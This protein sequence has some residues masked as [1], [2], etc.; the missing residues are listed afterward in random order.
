MLIELY[1]GT[2]TRYYSEQ[3]E[4]SLT[5][6]GASSPF[7]GPSN[8][9][10]VVDPVELQGIVSDWREKASEKL[11]EHLPEPLSWQEGMLPP[12]EAASLTFTGYG[13]AILF[14]A[15][16]VTE[17]QPRPT[18][19]QKTWDKD[20][21]VE[22]LMKAT[23]NNAI[24][25]VLNS[26]L[27]LPCNFNFGIGMKDPASQPVRCSSLDMLW[28]SL[29]QLNEATWKATPEKIAEWRRIEQT[30]DMTFERQA[31][32]G[33]SV[34]FTMCKLAREKRLPMKLHF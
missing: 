19:F 7:T 24:W 22:Q 34:F 14:A 23:Q 1:V 9:N 2:L 3:W 4:N 29:Q 5:K 18:T 30:E 32:F 26:T 8:P 31:Q 33:F 10:K 15:Y 27:W 28:N 20:P 17:L 16:T 6:Q 12:Y 21:A 11:K 13:G 25:E